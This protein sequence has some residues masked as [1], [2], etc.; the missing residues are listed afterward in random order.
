[1]KQ[2]GA[3]AGVTDVVHLLYRPVFQ[4]CE[5]WLFYLMNKN[6]PRK[7]RKMKTQGNIFQTKEQ[8]KSL[9]VILNEMEVNDLLDKE[10]KMKS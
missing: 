6:Q 1:M 9:E 7:P 3:Q 4:D 5:K 8:D 2:P 10:F